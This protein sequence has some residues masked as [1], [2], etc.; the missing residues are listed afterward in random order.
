MYKNSESWEML[1][2]DILFQWSI[3]YAYEADR[4]SHISSLLL[5]YL[6]LLN[7]LKFNG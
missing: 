3:I 6:K 5:F 2:S 7:L 4:Q 1:K